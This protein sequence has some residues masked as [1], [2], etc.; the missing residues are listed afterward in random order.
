MITFDFLT[1]VAVGIILFQRAMCSACF[2]ED[3]RIEIGQHRLTRVGV[4]SV[5]IDRCRTFAAEP[6]KLQS[7]LEHY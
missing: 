1:G 3:V 7:I 5:Q 4:E 2:A 6:I